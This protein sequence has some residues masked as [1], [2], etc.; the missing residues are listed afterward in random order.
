MVDWFNAEF[1]LRL[2][3]SEAKD[4][5]AYLETIGDG[6]EPYEKTPYY[7]DAEMEEFVF[8]L[9]TYRYLRQQGKHALVGTTF[10]TIAAEITNHKWE[11]QDP[12]YRPVLEKMASLMEEAYSLNRAGRY[13]EVERLVDAYRRLYRDNVEHLR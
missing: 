9:S 11:L 13:A 2:S 6:V 8:F 10:R 12:S 1:A 3:D 7:L 4:L 5:T